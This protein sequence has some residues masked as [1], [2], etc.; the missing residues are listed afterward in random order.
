MLPQMGEHSVKSCPTAFAG[1]LYVDK[2]FG[3]DEALLQ[4]V[5]AQQTHLSLDAVA[6][7]SL[8]LAGHTR[9][10]HDADGLRGTRLAC[11]WRYYG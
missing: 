7:L 6:L 8:F 2:F 5:I 1:R 4:R 9:I 3:D 10:D 11:R